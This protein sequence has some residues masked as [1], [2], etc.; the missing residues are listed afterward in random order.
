MDIYKTINLVNGKIYIGK[1]KNCDGD[2]LGSG[3]LI[4]RAIKKYGKENF[5]KEIIDTATTVE[6]LNEKEIFWID[7]LNSKDKTIGYNLA[8]GGDGGDLISNSSKKEHFLEYCRNRKGEKNGMYGRKHS[9]ESIKKMKEKKKG[10]RVGIPTW[11]KGMSIKNYS[12]NYKNF[13]NKDKRGPDKRTK[14]KKYIF[15]SPEKISYEIN[16]DEFHEFLNKHAINASVINHF[17]NKGVIPPPRNMGVINN[18]R[19][20]LTGWEIK[21]VK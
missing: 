7:K 17:T 3:V 8:D 15:I 2:Y 11:N 18:E 13:F 16:G 5:K 14:N 6:E 19:K 9:P 1:N 20:N 10:Q 4:R 21:R 12:E